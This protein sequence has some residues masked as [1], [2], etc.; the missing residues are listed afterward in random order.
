MHKKTLTLSAI[1]L[2]VLFI[3]TSCKKASSPP[4]VNGNTAHTLSNAYYVRGLL[5]TTWVYQGNDNKEECQTTGAV[6]ADFLT[7]GPHNTLLGVK[8]QLTDS[9]NPSP[10][11]ADI[12]SW[13]GKTFSARTDTLSFHAYT[14]SFEY[15]D[16]LGRQLSTEYVAYNAGTSLTVNSVTYNGLSQY[17]LDSVTPYKSYLVKGTVTAKLAHYGDSVIHNF[18]QG[19]FAINVIEAK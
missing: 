7:Y 13:V 12:L 1:F 8:F 5:D 17:Y 10:K 19:V 6:C 9:A 4:A 18:S 15:P 11:A 14:F 2:A 3:A 16:S